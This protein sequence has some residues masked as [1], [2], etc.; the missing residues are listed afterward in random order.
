MGTLIAVGL[1]ADASIAKAKH[2]PAEFLELAGLA[3]LIVVGEI[4]QISEDSFT[5]RTDEVLAGVEKAKGLRLRK[6]V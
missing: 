3:D 6:F 1:L 5:L 2:D 4:A